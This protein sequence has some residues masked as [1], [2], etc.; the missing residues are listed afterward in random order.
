MFLADYKRLAEAKYEDLY[1]YL[2][3]DRASPTGGNYLSNLVNTLRDLLTYYAS[4]SRVEVV[5]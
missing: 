5:S 1:S 3:L 2:S 4:L